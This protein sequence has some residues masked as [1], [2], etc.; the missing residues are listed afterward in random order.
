MRVP[1]GGRLIPLACAMLLGTQALDPA[2]AATL[3]ATLKVL[4]DPSASGGAVA[5]SPAAAEIDRQVQ[6]LAGS[7]ELVQE[8][9]G[10]AGEV[11]ADLVKGTG[12]DARKL[13]VAL[14]QAKGDPA[15][16]AAMLSP[17]TLQHLRELSVKIS[18]ARR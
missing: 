14:D 1:S 4:A 2:S 5:G 17:R 12:G 6:S 11:L 18:D 3:A 16:F 9:Y 13:G 10:L 8:L 7:P 15:A